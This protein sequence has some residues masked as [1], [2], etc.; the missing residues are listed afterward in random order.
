M[1]DDKKEKGSSVFP[2][3]MMGGL[4]IVIHLL[5]L[6]ITQPFEATGMNVF[7][8]PNDPVNLLIFFAIM[9][10]VTLTI[11]LIAKFWKKQLIQVIIL[12]SI[13]YTTF[14]VF[15]TLLFFVV[16]EIFSLSLSITAAA[17]LIVAL[18]KHPEWY[19]IDLCGIIVGVGSIGIF[20]ISLSVFLVI[21]LLIGLSIYDAI[22]VY[23]TKHM[24]DL[25][26]AVMDLKLPV[27]MVIPKIR[28][29]SL[30]KETKGIKEK[31]EENEERE[32]FFLGLGDIVMPGILVVSVFQNIP[33]NGLLVALSVM[34]GTLVGFAVLMSVVIK[35]KPQAGLP[36]LCSG[37]ILGYVVSSLLLFGE[38]AGLVLPF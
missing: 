31:L 11:L 36:Y 8:N 35:G 13:A 37:A 12:G 33:D 2:M 26:D 30:L 18:I 20:G 27:M 1:T 16:P 14:F 29:Y 19:I 4:F 9:L 38:L 28:R 24:I 23:K 7:D 5:S 34:I 6:L 15:Y 25:A 3:F 17:I 10:V 21:V 32:A 22:S